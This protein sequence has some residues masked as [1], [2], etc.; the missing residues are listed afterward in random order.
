MVT[1]RLHNKQA[2]IQDWEIVCEDDI[3]RRW[4]ESLRDPLGPSGADPYPDL[5]LAQMAVDRIGGEIVQFDPPTPLREGV[6]Y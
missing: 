2:I 1:L 5:T 3:L 4:L 6:T